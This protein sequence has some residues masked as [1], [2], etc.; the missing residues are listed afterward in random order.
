[1][2]AELPGR[3]K[4]EI[5]ILRHG[6]DRLRRAWALH[7]DEILPDFIRKNPATRPWLWWKFD[8]PQ[9]PVKCWANMDIKEAQR[10]RLGGKGTPSFEVLACG[11]HFSKGI[12]LSYVDQFDVAY[13]N[14]RAKDIHGKLIDTDYKEGDFEAVAYDKDDPPTFESEAVYLQRKEL[15]NPIEK[16]Y[17]A[18]HPELLEPEKVGYEEDEID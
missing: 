6:G 3:A 16:A 18:K 5:F 2:P 12:P 15:L 17:L 7:R 13:Y 9:E 8:A 1:M 14:G 4:V 11:L 10:K